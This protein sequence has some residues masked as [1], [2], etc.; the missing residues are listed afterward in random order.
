MRGFCPAGG[1]LSPL[2]PAFCLKDVLPL[3]R[4]F[5]R[6]RPLNAMLQL[7][8]GPP[9][10]A[11][12]LFLGGA[13]LGLGKGLGGASRDGRLRRGLPVVLLKRGG[14]GLGMVM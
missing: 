11:A 12:S 1:S 3:R 9:V 8:A 2:D 7:Y 4:P 13:C 5:Q 14:R 10:R 6:R